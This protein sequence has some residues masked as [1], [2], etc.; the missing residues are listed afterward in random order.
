MDLIRSPGEMQ[1]AAQ[2][3]RAAGGTLALVPTMGALHDGHLALV[4]A[5]ESL[6]SRVV[7]SVFVNPTQF[8]PN[9]DLDQYPRDLLGDMKL[10]S[11]LKVDVVFAPDSQAMYPAGFQTRVSVTRLPDHLCGLGRPGHFDGVAQVVLKLF[12]LCLPDVAVFGRKDFQQLRVIE[13]MVR[14]LDV[15]VRIVGH[16]TVRE[17]DGLALSSRNRY[18]SPAERRL[19]PL[20][21][22]TLQDLASEVRGGARD[23]RTLVQDARARL[24]LAGFRVEYLNAV[25]PDTLDDLAETRRPLLFAIAA[26]LGSTRLID[27]ELVD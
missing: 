19:A 25:D 4:R 1:A 5:A 23:V 15:P 6:A 7:V 17:P 16:P 9:E 20:L 22:E 8:G 14:D 12:H 27:N 11:A 18:L 21:H 13:R 10:L 26:R 3:I 24:D 2:A